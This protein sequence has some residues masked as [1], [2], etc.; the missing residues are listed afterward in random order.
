MGVLHYHDR[1]FEFEDRLL[2][3]VQ[4]VVGLKLKRSEYFYL[5][6][7]P[8]RETGAGRQAVWISNGSAMH[9]EFHGSR[10]PALNREDRTTGHER[11]QRCRP[12]SVR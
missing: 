12:E 9:F 5:S 1:T 6:W 8:G 10:T 3:H 11:E 7:L 2:S 4:I